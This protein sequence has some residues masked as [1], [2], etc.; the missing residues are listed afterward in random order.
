M[1]MKNR[2]LPSTAR[3]GLLLAQAFLHSIEVPDLSHK[4]RRPLP[5][6]RNVAIPNSRL[7]YR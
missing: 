7:S 3:T 6:R 1:K 5:T 4:P 2:G